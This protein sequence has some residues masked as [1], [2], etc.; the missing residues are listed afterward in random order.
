MEA[1]EEITYIRHGES[2]RQVLSN[3]DVPCMHEGMPPDIWNIPD[4]QVPLTHLGISQAKALGKFLWGNYR[5][6]HVIVHSGYVRTIQ[7][8]NAILDVIPEERHSTIDIKESILLRERD[9]GYTFFMTPE[10]SSRAFPWFAESRRKM[11]PYFVRPPGGESIAD[12]QQRLLIFL[13][14]FQQLCLEKQHTRIWFVCHGRVI[15]TMRFIFEHYSIAQAEALLKNG[16]YPS[17]CS[18][19]RYE[20]DLKTSQL[21]LSVYNDT[22]WM[23]A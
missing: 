22:R 6:P 14:E 4:H 8:A 5:L 18:I 9:P 17:N 19:T 1:V 11:G 3:G 2:V 13:R 10:E 21:R 12:V 23:Y 20:R 15:Q 16:P 7:T